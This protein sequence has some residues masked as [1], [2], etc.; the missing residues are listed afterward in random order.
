MNEARTMRMTRVIA[1]ML[2]V[3]ALMACGAGS[4]GSPTYPAGSIAAILEA[5]GR[6]D[7]L[8]EI[9]ER[10]MPPVALDSMTA[11]EL[12][13]TIFAPTDDAFDALPPGTLEWLRSD[14]NV[15]DLQSVF[16]HHVLI[17]SYSLDELRSKAQSG[18]GRVESLTEGSPIQLTL[19]GDT[20]LVDGAAVIDGDIR[21]ENGVIHVIDAVMIPDSVAI[22]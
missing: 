22:P 6:L 4:T 8:M 13:I 3:S 14:E 10:D 7:T 11:L 21:A 9:T 2:M 18:A 12:D 1:G 5:D 19:T 16:D 20:L 15:S 17:K